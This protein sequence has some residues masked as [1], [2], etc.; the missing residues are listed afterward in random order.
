[1]K[2]LFLYLMITSLL[3][4]V[5]YTVQAAQ[6][7]N[8]TDIRLSKL[9]NKMLGQDFRVKFRSEKNAKICGSESDAYI[10]QVEM[11]KYS[12]SYDEKN[13]SRIQ[14]R[15]V[16]I[17]KFYAISPEELVEPNPRLFDPDKCME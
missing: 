13:G 7:A 12:R 5:P 14:D 8:E 4:M 16:K 11:N 1:M 9:A 6:Q 2:N 15:W 10:G 17:D 3:P